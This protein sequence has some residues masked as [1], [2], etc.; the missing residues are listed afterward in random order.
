MYDNNAPFKGI[1]MDFGGPFTKTTMF[2]FTGDRDQSPNR[3]LNMSLWNF[4]RNN[5]ENIPSFA[6]QTN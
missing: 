3:S 4:H 1:R 2:E 6:Y 5:F